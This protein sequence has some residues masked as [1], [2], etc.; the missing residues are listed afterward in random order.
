MQ[1]VN[2]VIGATALALVALSWS[3][4]RAQ[5]TGGA[6][7][8]PVPAL[9]ASSQVPPD[10]G[11]TE[12]SLGDEILGKAVPF[13][14]INGPE[15]Q[16]V[17]GVVGL[18]LFADGEKMAP[19]GVPF[20]PL[21]SLDLNFN[22]WVWPQEGLYLYSDTR[23]WGQK[24]TQGVTNGDQGQF[25]F[26]KREF[27]FSGGAAWNY[28][29][30]L[31]ARV[32]AYSYNSFNRGVDLS[33]PHGFKDGVG[34]ENRYYLSSI[35]R[36]L[37]TRR[38]DVTEAAYIGVGYYPTKELFDSN[39][40][41]Y[42]PSAFLDAYLVLDFWEEHRGYLYGDIQ[43]IAERP[44][45]ARTLYTDLGLALRPLRKVWGLEFRVGAETTYDVQENFARNLVYCALRVV[46]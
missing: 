14:E 36:L 27:D 37:G 25:D 23:F 30:Y 31:E 29:R 39:G 28:Y 17:W 26:S 7:L 21:F 32:F 43:L 46:Y 15:Y 20:D 10:G 18:R 13:E 44:L 11:N 42:K 6:P 35:Y 5:E 16:R 33:K 41:S 34:L 4:A 24:A 2:L 38:Y 45:S 12:W 19:N 8:P 9:A 3:A 40:N 22:L 1:R